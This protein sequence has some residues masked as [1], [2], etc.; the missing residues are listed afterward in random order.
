[1]EEVVFSHLDYSKALHLGISQKQC[2]VAGMTSLS[3]M[4]PINLHQR[5]LHWSP[6]EHV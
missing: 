5:E 2:Y 6:G 3:L 1:M 4:G